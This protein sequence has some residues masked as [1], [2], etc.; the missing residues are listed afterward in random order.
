MKHLVA[1]QF[2]LNFLYQGKDVKH[3]VG[4]CVLLNFLEQREGHYAICV[5]SSLSTQFSSARGRN[6]TC[7]VAAAR[8]TKMLL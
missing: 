6:M 3:F 8:Q 2:R 4:Y 7:F 5:I 1:Y